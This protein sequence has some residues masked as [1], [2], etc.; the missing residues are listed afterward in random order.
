MT[1]PEPSP[2]YNALKEIS[3]TQQTLLES[4]RVLE[5]N[6]KIIW[7]LGV[8]ITMLTLLTLSFIGANCESCRNSFD[9]FQA[10]RFQ[11]IGKFLYYIKSNIFFQKAMIPAMTPRKT[12]A[13]RIKRIKQCPPNQRLLAIWH[14]ETTKRMKKRRP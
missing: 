8:L 2:N 3:A 4:I 13:G 5:Q 9:Q 12:I 6:V 7:A 1:I 10:W 11:N 14:F